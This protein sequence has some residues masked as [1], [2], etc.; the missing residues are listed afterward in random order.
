MACNGTVGSCSGGCGSGCTGGS[1]CSSGCNCSGF[2]TGGCFTACAV[3]CNSNCSGCTGSCSGCDGCSGCSGC[4]SG[5]ASTC[6][7]DC[8][9]TCKGC[10]SGCASTC[11][12]CGGG[13]KGTC[14]SGCTGGCIGY[15][16]SGCTNSTQT[17][18]YNV[19]VAMST[20]IKAAEVNKLRAFINY[21]V[22]TRRNHT[23]ST[24]S[25]TSAEYLAAAGW[26]N[27]L[28]TNLKKVIDVGGTA[29][30]GGVITAETRNELVN[31]AKALYNTVIGKP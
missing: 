22:N 9:G 2:C 30:A 14:N 26:W 7:G 21:E 23:L 8:K 11:S 19:V 1:T 13:C 5:C 12:G 16:N 18:N 31:K 17:D 6:S 28:R 4:G 27:Q 10:G 29:T 15:C 24:N 25:D 20:I 3:S